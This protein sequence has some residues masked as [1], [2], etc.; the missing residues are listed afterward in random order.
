MVVSFD[1]FG[2]LLA[3]QTPADPASAVAVELS[4][5]GVS[6][7]TDWSVAY[8]ESHTPVPS[9]GETSLTEHVVHA[10]ESRGV[11]PDRD[12]CARAVATAFAPD[13][14]TRRGARIALA[15]AAHKGQI[16]VCSNCSVSGLV[17][18][19]LAR[20]AVDRS[21]DAVITSVGCGWRKPH[22]RAFEAVAERF[23]TS[24]DALVHVGDNPDTDGGIETIGG[25][26]IDVNE[27]PLETIPARLQEIEG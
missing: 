4:N 10:L 26:F 27:C 19:A 11:E 21:F 7:P 22:P 16:A 2:T 13:V 25:T 18:R 9:G 17:E 23:G 6:V 5:R 15:A 14:R 8:G 12:R 1:C 20:S 3:V 24:G